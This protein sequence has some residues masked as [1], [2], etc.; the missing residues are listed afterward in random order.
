MSW[1][2]ILKAKVR[3]NM[4]DYFEG[5]LPDEFEESPLHPNNLVSEEEFKM[6]LED[7][8]TTADGWKTFSINLEN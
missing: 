2:N 6:A 4:A 5:L 7:T 1:S 8:N 3:T